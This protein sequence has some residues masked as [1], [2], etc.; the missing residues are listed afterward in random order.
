[1]SEKFSGI[2]LWKMVVGF[3]GVLVLTGAGATELV[4]LVGGL[5]LALLGFGYAFWERHAWR[6]PPRLPQGLKCAS[7]P[8][9]VARED[10]PDAPHYQKLEIE[11][12]RAIVPP[13]FLVVCSAPISRIAGYVLEPEPVEHRKLTFSKRT[14]HEA[15]IFVQPVRPG[16]AVN[17]DSIATKPD[18]YLHLR[19]FSTEPIRVKAIKRRK[20]RLKLPG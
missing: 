9:G 14:I 13:S 7:F 8:K 15:S 17:R 19:V 10:S 18:S 1:M 20:R 12:E 16:R 11:I 6:R 4:L 5:I 3:G 2:D